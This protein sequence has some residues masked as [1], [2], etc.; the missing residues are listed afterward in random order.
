VPQANP[1]PPRPPSQPARNSQLSA[2]LAQLG[3]SL[4]QPTPPTQTPTQS[5]PRRGSAFA[6]ASH[7]LLDPFGPVGQSP[8]G[9]RDS[10]EGRRASEDAGEPEKNKGKRKADEM[11]RYEWSFTRCLPV[12]TDLLRDD[13]FVK[14]V[15]KVSRGRAARAG[16]GCGEGEWRGGWRA[17]FVVSWEAWVAR[18]WDVEAEGGGACGGAGRAQANGR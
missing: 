16:Y 4:P 17:G 9:R 1:S 7:N 3:P 14:E 2:L 10:A 8:G 6:G 15:R 11:D 5:S 12:L 13:E 18:A